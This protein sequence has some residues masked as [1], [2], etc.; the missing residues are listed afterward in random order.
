MRAKGLSWLGIPVDDVDAAIAFFAG[1]L[2]I[3]VELHDGDFAVLRLPSGQT[4]ELFG[5]ALRAE[6]QF[7]TG[8]V[9]GF[10]VDDVTASRAELEAGGVEF[11]GPV[12]TGEDGRAW[13][14]LP[15]S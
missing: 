11:I 3:E 4:V 1:Q 2:G 5:P 8:P 12:H 6:P 7:A 14:A 9:T 15:R 13:S 10:E